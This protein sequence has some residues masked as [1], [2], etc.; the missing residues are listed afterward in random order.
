MKHKPEQLTIHILDAFSLLPIL[1]NSIFYLFNGIIFFLCISYA[2]ADT[3]FRDDF[4]GTSVNASTWT[5][6]TG[7][8]SYYGSTQIRAYFPPVSN[9]LLHLQLDSYNPTGYSFFG[10]EIITQNPFT[11]GTGVIFE[12][13]ARMTTP[14]TGLVGGAFLYN[15]FT[16]TDHS[17]IDFE[18]LS[19][20][21][22]KVQTNIYANQ[23][24]GAGSPAFD[25]TLDITQ[26]NTYRVEWYPSIVCWY[27]NDQLVRTN[28][29]LVPS[30]PL[31]LHLNFYVPSC[32]S[33]PLACNSNLVPASS[34][35]NN[36]TWFLDVDWVQVTY[37][38]PL[39]T[40][41]L[42]E[43]LTVKNPD[44][45]WGTVV[46]NVGGISC[47]SICGANF[48]GGTLVTLTAIPIS[49]YQF[50]GWGGACHGYGNSCIV[51]MNAAET[52]TANFAPFKVHQ[53]TWK[54]VISSIIQRGN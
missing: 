18:L 6:P 4:N 10:S 22:T 5:Y 41:C 33:W 53:P 3:I 14:V 49:G 11:L 9:G 25:G 2:H 21:P 17:E 26:F 30:D 7:N 51:T 20:F 19:N 42:P 45:A 31:F 34:Q 46:S 50:T 35:S 38:V 39:Q 1:E 15:Y 8:P 12:T 48:T 29:T 52:V 40:Q 54:R 47:G 23:A 36:Q 24:L 16:A 13:S 28:T 44:S 43:T 37:N 27:V 32:Q